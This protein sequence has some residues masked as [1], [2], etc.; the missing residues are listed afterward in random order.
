[1]E[2][3]IAEQALA[4]LKDASLEVSTTLSLIQRE[5][6]E[7]EFVEYRTAAGTA[8]GH[9]LTEVI[10]PIVRQHPDLE[11]EELKKPPQE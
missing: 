3:H 9:L 1:M 6:T 11:P 5:C 8:M 10:E 2:R 4:A 7:E